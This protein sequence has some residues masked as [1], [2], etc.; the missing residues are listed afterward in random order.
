MDADITKT[1]YQSSFEHHLG[2]NF[3]TYQDGICSISLK[4]LPIHLNIARGVHGGIITSLLDI[5]MS[6]AVTCTIADRSAEQVVTM[7][8]NTNFLRGATEGDTLNARGE[9]IKR[10]STIVYVE[11]SIHDQNGKL[12]A[13]ASGDW[14]IKK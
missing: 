1:R 9:I 5:A 11:G 14:F 12:I 13:K 4:I 7:Q 2:V 10:G 3:E 6:G 8:M